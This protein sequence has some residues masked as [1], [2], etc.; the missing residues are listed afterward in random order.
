ML[1]I[2]ASTVLLDFLT[3][4]FIVAT[5]CWWIANKKLRVQ[6]VH[7]VEQEVEWLYA[8]DIHCNSFFP[9]FLMLY[10]LQYFCLP[11]LLTGGFFGT[12]L[13]NILYTLA[14]SY[15]FHVTA[16]GYGALPFLKDTSFFY[17]PVS[18]IA[19][20]FLISL[21]FNFNFCIFVMNCYFGA[22]K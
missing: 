18:I 11:A 21:L 6:G 7:S 2:M 1:Y 10:V 14:F 22:S 3:V 17:Y 19:L 13:S 20:L 16:L 9:L 4:G 5:I 15:Y 12:F 8:F